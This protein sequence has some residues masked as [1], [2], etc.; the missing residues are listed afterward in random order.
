[1]LACEEGEA[2]QIDPS[3]E[4]DGELSFV[5]CENGSDTPLPP[6][7]WPTVHHGAQGA[8]HFSLALLM[9]GL[10]PEHREVEVTLRVE[11][12]EDE[13]CEDT[14]MIVSRTLLADEDVLEG[15]GDVAELHDVILVLEKAPP[16]DG[17]LVVEARDACGRTATR[18]FTAG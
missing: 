5:A 15:E 11:T 18:M 3:C 12:C 16:E 2:L 4:A 6:D 1:V 7:A 10:E 8:L 14:S 17:R 9:E 13:V